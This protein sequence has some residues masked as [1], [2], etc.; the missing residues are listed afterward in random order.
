MDNTAQE[1]NSKK[2]S[3]STKGVII[4]GLVYG[5]SN[6]GSNENVALG[7]ITIRIQGAS[8]ATDS[9]DVTSGETGEFSSRLLSPGKYKVTPIDSKAI[10]FRPP[11]TIPV[12]ND[13]PLEIYMTPAGT[14]N[15]RRGN[16]HSFMPIIK[17]NIYGFLVE[18][19]KK[20]IANID[21]SVKSVTLDPAKSNKGL[22][23]KLA[24]FVSRKNATENEEGKNK[25]PEPISIILKTNAL[26]SF[27]VR[28]R[29]PNGAYIVKCIDPSK[30]YTFRSRFMVLKGYYLPPLWF[31]GYTTSDLDELKKKHQERKDKAPE[32]EK[33]KEAEESTT[34]KKGGTE[35]EDAKNKEGLEEGD[36]KKAADEAARI[37]HENQ[38]PSKP[39]KTGGSLKPDES[40]T[41]A[42]PETKR[43]TI[44][45][46]AT[47]TATL[48]RPQT[49]LQPNLR[50]YPQPTSFPAIET[51]VRP[52]QFDEPSIPQQSSEQQRTQSAQNAQS[53]Q[54]NRQRRSSVRSPRIP[55]PAKNAA[56]QA[57]RGG[58]K[59]VLN[60]INTAT[61]PVQ[62]VLKKYLIGAAIII[63]LLIIIIQFFGPESPAS[64]FSS[65]ETSANPGNPGNPTNPNPGNPGVNTGGGLDYAI[66]I[67]DPTILPDNIKQ[68]IASNWP[69]ALLQNLDNI[70]S[71][72]KSH[73]WNP[74]FLLSLWIE[75]S[76][77][78]AGTS[79]A[80]GNPNGYTDALGCDPQHPTSNINSSLTCF[81]N[82]YGSYTKSFADFMCNY[83]ESKDAPCTFSTNPNFPGSIKSVYATLVPNG[84]GAEINITPTT[85]PGGGSVTATCPIRGGIITCGSKFNTVNNCG[86]C[87]PNTDYASDMDQCTY[88][89]INY[90]EDVGASAGT[91]V[92]L[93]SL[94]GES[95]IW[96]FYNEQQSGIG[97]TIMYKGNDSHDITYVIEFH[98]V[99]G[100]SS[101]KRG[102]S[103][104]I[105]AKTCTG[106]SRCN[107][108]HIEFY[109]LPATGVQDYVDASKTFCQ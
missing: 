88:N 14:P 51:I 97:S 27:A 105:G 78:Q 23:E 6:A 8:R 3:E 102:L 50:D 82:Q 22:I 26:G 55:N 39:P 12:N 10:Y 46:S 90:A 76:G 44:S 64:P 65:G 104:D 33:D 62:S 107:H 96:N 9:Q 79:N 99:A 30:K 18:R 48:E 94:N 100:G 77:G 74:S 72:A 21:V 38:A 108:V 109:K 71:T 4:S 35:S 1:G 29:L 81:F 45:R 53:A 61:A 92:I 25:E 93:P 7:G 40:P 70:V 15:R 47:G 54:G 52:P 89:G 67:N 43:E 59:E 41:G 75:E 66:L 85:T 28:Q 103:G 57:A 63:I 5:P 31:T 49:E 20:P 86:H 83:S 19:Q 32:E 68:T 84:P 13:T 11:L 56:S 42:T 34:S 2:S 37:I 101:V 95:I 98:H 106:D 73:N 36:G 87:N 60:A 16:H 69:N 17:N 80:D 91:N 58:E 24:S